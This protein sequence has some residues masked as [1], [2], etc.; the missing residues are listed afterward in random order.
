MSQFLRVIGIDVASKKL[1]I[2]DS[3]GKLAAVIDN[4][5]E[6]IEIKL[7]KKITDPEKT[8]V[9]CESSGGWEN[10]MVDM[11]LE[12]KVNVAVVNP[13]QAMHF[14]KGHGYIEKTD[15]IDAKVMR[16][17]GE[18][19]EIHLTKPRSDREKKFR[20][21]SRRRVQVLTMISQEGNRKILCRDKGSLELIDESLEMLKKQLKLIDWKLK[22]FVEELAKDTPIVRIIA[23]VPGVGPV[24]T[25]TLC[26][27]LPEL[28]EISRSKLAKLVGVAPITKQSGESD[29]KRNVRGGRSTVRRAL[30]MAALVATKHNPVIRKFYLKLLQ[31]GKPKK[32]A[33]L[34]C[35][36]K[37]LLMIHDMVR[38]EQMWDPD[39]KANGRAVASP[40]TGTA[41]SARH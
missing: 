33:L 24:T 1:D 11:L 41:C 22:E 25:A 2:S 3:W 7:L 39:R 6:S 34:A 5:V 16:L 37:L 20:A 12:A 29:R 38:H 4:N 21:L 14:A 9:V 15:T 36:R 31:K 30:Y 28:G 8:L 13:L 26:C 19:V 17:F 27:E 10:E 32:L 35:M 40:T 18:Q 23:S